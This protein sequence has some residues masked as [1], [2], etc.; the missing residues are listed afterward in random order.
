MTLKENLPQVPENAA[1][2]NI[3]IARERAALKV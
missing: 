1:E 2:M 3:R